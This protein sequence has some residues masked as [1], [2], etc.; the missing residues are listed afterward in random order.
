MFSFENLDI[1]DASDSQAPQ[2]SA[3]ERVSSESSNR[4]SRHLQVS[5][6]SMKMN[7]VYGALMDCV[8]SDRHEE[9]RSCANPVRWM[10][11]TDPV[12]QE[13]PSPR[14]SELCSLVARL[15]TFMKQTNNRFET[16]YKEMSFVKSAQIAMMAKLGRRPSSS[17]P[18]SMDTSPGNDITTGGLRDSCEIPAQ[19]GGGDADSFEDLDTKFQDADAARSSVMGTNVEEIMAAMAD[20][21]ERLTNAEERIMAQNQMSEQFTSDF[22]AVKVLKNNVH[23][24][25][26]TIRCQ[27]QD[28]K[29]LVSC[30]LLNLARGKVKHR[31]SLRMKSPTSV[32]HSWRTAN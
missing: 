8:P 20:I 23:H 18:I 22:E 19:Q 3:P 7:R 32:F 4:P 9:T 5:P 27:H 6:R 16:V 1:R 15:E 31:T 17:V 10:F 26:S 24:E 21:E 11:D 29:Y 2:I 12:V 28:M 30:D 14:T 25:L 13:L